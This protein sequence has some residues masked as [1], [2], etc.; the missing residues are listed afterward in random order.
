MEKFTDWAANTLIPLARS[1]EKEVAA[2]W[3]TLADE[4]K[5]AI[6]IGILGAVG[7]AFTALAIPVMAAIW[8]FLAIGA[9]VW[10]VYEAFVEWKAWMAGLC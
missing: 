6:L 9:A 10:V 4:S 1:A 7:A 3:S 2:F 5:S 8:P